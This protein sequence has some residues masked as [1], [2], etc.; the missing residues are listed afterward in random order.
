MHLVVAE[1]Y[2]SQSGYVIGLGV[3]GLIKWNGYYLWL[4]N[5]YYAE[6]N[7]CLSSSF[8]SPT[9]PLTHDLAGL[10]VVEFLI[11]VED[12][13]E[14]KGGQQHQADTQ[15]HVACKRSKIQSLRGKRWQERQN[16]N[17]WVQEKKPHKPE[18]QQSRE[19]VIWTDAVTDQSQ[20]QPPFTT[21]NNFISSHFSNPLS[22]RYLAESQSDCSIHNHES[23]SQERAQTVVSEFTLNSAS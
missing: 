14:G 18:I 8:H 22:I 11:P 4:C 12:P 23:S 21:L 20:S 5:G 16:E 7:M 19:E 6:I 3:K 15:E 1:I 10:F 13:Q 9:S 2:S 17:K